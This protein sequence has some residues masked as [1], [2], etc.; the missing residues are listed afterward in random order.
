LFGNR[1]RVLANS[2]RLLIDAA[3][4]IPGKGKKT[5]KHRSALAQVLLCHCA[6]PVGR[7]CSLLGILA[8]LCSTHF[9]NSNF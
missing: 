2:G 1:H 3:K 5:L 4:R 9:L 7:L 8:S 6:H